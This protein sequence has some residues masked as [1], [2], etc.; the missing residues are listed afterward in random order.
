MGRGAVESVFKVEKH[1]AQFAQRVQSRA[2]RA[3][4][5]DAA[6]H[7]KRVVPGY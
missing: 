4:K 5:A 6:L 7:L 1:R 3:S 2:P